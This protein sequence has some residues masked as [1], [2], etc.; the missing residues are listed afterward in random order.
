MYYRDHVE[1][2]GS[3]KFN[4]DFKRFTDDLAEKIKS[5]GSRDSESA[6]NI[7][8]VSENC[9]IWE[10]ISKEL[11][12]RSPDGRGVAYNTRMVPDASPSTLFGDGWITDVVVRLFGHDQS[13]SEEG[14]SYG[15]IFGEAEHWFWAAHYMLSST[16]RLLREKQTIPSPQA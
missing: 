13:E 2:K 10:L 1:A 5:L 7:E 9:S 8:N 11:K 4:D 16:E 3:K 15:G 12:A 14:I 6:L